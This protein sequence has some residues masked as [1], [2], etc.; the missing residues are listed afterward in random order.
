MCASL[1]LLRWLALVLAAVGAVSGAFGQA[2]SAGAWMDYYGPVLGLAP[3]GLPGQSEWT[4]QVTAT[5]EAPERLAALGVAGAGRGEKI[6]LL[7]RD[8]GY[9]TIEFPA[10]GRTVT[11][12]LAY[13]VRFGVLPDHDLSTGKV[14]AHIT[15]TVVDPSVLRQY[16]FRHPVSGEVFTLIFEDGGW[17]L[18]LDPGP[19][20]ESQRVPF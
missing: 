3:E 12:P 16:Q 5:V 19:N 14:P 13:R 20:A 17:R 18:T 8:N 11:V 2:E 6:V 9:W 10:S 4:D 1:R 7:N 15:G